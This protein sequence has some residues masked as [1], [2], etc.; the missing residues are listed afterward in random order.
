LLGLGIPTFW[1][2]PE[3]YLYTANPTY[4]DCH[5]TSIDHSNQ[6]GSYYPCLHP[7]VFQPTDLNTDD[8]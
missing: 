6:T 7:D 4:H 8:W 5:T 2:P 3:E 1:N